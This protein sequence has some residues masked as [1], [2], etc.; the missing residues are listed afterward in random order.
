MKFPRRLLSLSVVLALS[1][2]AQFVYSEEEDFDE[3]DDELADF[4]GDED[5]VSLATGSKILIHKAPS[6]ASVITSE[7]IQEMGFQDIDEVLETIPGFHVSRNKAG[8]EPIY[9][10]RGVTTRFNPQV[11]MLVNGVPITNVYVGNRGQVWGG[12]PLEGV[13]RIEVIRGP[14]SALYG[15]DAFAG[16]I[17]IITKGTKDIK[18]AE[19]G[20]R[21]GSFDSKSVWFSNAIE[22]NDIKASIA[23]QYYETKGH[24]EIIEADVQTFLDNI[25]GTNA[26]YAPGPMSNMRIS[27]ELRLQADYDKFVFRA[28]LQKR[29]RGLGIGITGALTPSSRSSS[30]KINFDINY[31]DTNFSKNSELS[32]QISFFSTTLEIDGNLILFPP[33]SDIGFGAPFPDGVIGNPEVFERHQRANITYIFKGFIEHNIR[34]GI[35]YYYS[36][37]Y[38]VKESKNFA[39]GPNGEFLAPGSP[40]TNVS[41]TPFAFLPERDRT[42]N[43]LF[44][45]DEW[46]LANDWLATLGVRYDDY[47]DFGSTTNPRFALVWST[48]LNF[49]TKF[50]FGEAFRAPSMANLYAINNPAALG[51][52]NVKPEKI[53]TTELVFDYHP[54]DSIT[55]IFSLFTYK[56][57]DVIQFSPDEGLTTTT[58]KNIGKRSG[59]GFEL[60]LNWKPFTNFKLSANYSY[61]DSINNETN[62]ALIN[63]PNKQLFLMSNW[64]ITTNWNVNTQV[65][66]VMGRERAETD[67]RKKIDDNTWVNLSVRW[68]NDTEDL[69]VSLK[70]KNLFDA[71]LR[72]P[73]AANIPND[74]PLAGRSIHAELRYYY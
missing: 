67:L 35:G 59:S 73:T 16:V 31:N 4:Y 41:D 64:M 8:N 47:S 54:I 53:Q 60:E 5:F 34:T 13:A 38:K 71:E 51:S 68:K 7:Q 62:T 50:L 24:E 55:G 58:A 36:D 43:Y 74:L 15:A 17:N 69:E 42:N 66:S 70:A 26:S 63:V 40:V 1:C 19:I 37:I 28:G 18:K 48:S 57:E 72:E 49:T 46:Q 56:W 22:K 30:Q 25:F 32:A 20:A 21:V 33:G 29:T 61:Q 9:M 14:G 45:Q 65:Y 10:I 11:L 12:L 2:S 39:L 23:Y 3:Y 6:V 52:I 44:I 27:H